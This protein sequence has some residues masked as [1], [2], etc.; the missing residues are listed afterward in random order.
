MTEAKILAKR[1]GQR[2]THKSCT[3]K[4]HF[5]DKQSFA[6]NFF[7]NQTGSIDCRGHRSNISDAA[8][9][10]LL[11]TLITTPFKKTSSFG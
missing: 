8:A 10:L 3:L 5:T 7:C 9:L 4:N 6:S 2:F 1:E 11:Q